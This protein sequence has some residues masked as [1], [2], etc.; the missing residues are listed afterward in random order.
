M[1]ASGSQC[2]PQGGSVV[3]QGR[4]GP[5]VVSVVRTAS[6]G[7]G[8]EEDV[9]QVEVPRGA[10]AAQLKAQIEELYEVPGAMQKLSTST[11][12]DATAIEDSV[13]VESLA[14]G[15]IYLHP[16]PALDAGPFDPG[17]MGA[18]PTGE[19]H[20]A[21]AQMMGSLVGET[22]ESM[23]MGMDE[24]Q[25][26]SSLVGEAQESMEMRM[27]L[28]ES[29]RGVSYTVHF[30]RPRDAGGAAAGRKVS[31][32][33]DALSLVSDIQ[34]IVELEL[35]GA[36]GKEPAFLLLNGASLPSHLSLHLAGVDENGRTVTVAKEPPPLSGEEQMLAAA[37]GMPA[38]MPG[39]PGAGGF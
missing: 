32:T 22:Q 20:E 26:M 4:S 11:A 9:W 16:A 33:L 6:W 25:M 12:E 17:M 13:K 2:S 3:A 31:L 14:A 8:S 5:V 7:M 1:G 10:T 35:F 39:A 36:A 18:L 29:L 38:I 30:E 37:L 24:D 23:E 27:A 19:D 34:Q 21:M 15:R 28:V